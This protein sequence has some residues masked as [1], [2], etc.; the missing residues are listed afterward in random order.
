LRSNNL[1]GLFETKQ[2]SW[3]RA[4]QGAETS[5]HVWAKLGADPRMKKEPWSRHHVS[6]GLKNEPWFRPNE[7]SSFKPEE[8]KKL[9][10]LE[11]YPRTGLFE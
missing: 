2:G 6:N 4:T 10:A 1:K 11:L 7:G 8:V 9:A 5:G 3:N